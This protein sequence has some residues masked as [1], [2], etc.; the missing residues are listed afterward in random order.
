M[1]YIIYGF[2]KIIPIADSLQELDFW[3]LKL[4]ST[5]SLDNLMYCVIYKFNSDKKIIAEKPL[6]DYIKEYRLNS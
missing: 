1:K 6:M 5:V 3:V 4:M 2:N